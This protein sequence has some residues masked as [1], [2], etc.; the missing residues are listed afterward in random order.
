MAL[1][2]SRSVGR[3]TARLSRRIRGPAHD[4]LDCF[5]K[6][7][8]EACAQLSELSLASRRN[9]E[10]LSVRAP[11]DVFGLLSGDFERALFTTS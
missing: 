6:L 1:T 11:L 8:A 10:N 2:E 4:N 9:L 5:R 7:R 3:N